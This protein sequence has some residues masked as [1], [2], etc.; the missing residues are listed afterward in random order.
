MIVKKERRVWEKK[1]ESV[2]TDSWY[3]NLAIGFESEFLFPIPITTQNGFS[4]LAQL[5]SQYFE[6][7]FSYSEEYHDYSSRKYDSHDFQTISHIEKDTS[8]KNKPLN[9]P[10]RYY[11]SMIEQ[12]TAVNLAPFELVSKV[13]FGKNVLLN[14]FDELE[15]FFCFL[16]QSKAITNESCGFH[17]TIS[18]IP[19]EQICWYR[20]HYLTGTRSILKDFN[21]DNNMYSNYALK[22]TEIN[23]EQIEILK[24]KDYRT[25]FDSHDIS[26]DKYDAIHLKEFY[27]PETDNC[28]ICI[29]FRPIGNAW[30]HLK[31]DQIR[32]TILRML[33]NLKR[34]TTTIDK[35]DIRREMRKT[36]F[37]RN[38]V[39][40][41]KE[42]GVLF[43]E[44]S[45]VSMKTKE[46][47]MRNYLTD[48]RSYES[49]NAKFFYDRE[50]TKHFYITL[51][52]LQIK[53]ESLTLR[54][55][56]IP[57]LLQDLKTLINDKSWTENNLYQRC[58]SVSFDQL[59][60]LQIFNIRSCSL[61]PWVSSTHNNF[62]FLKNKKRSKYYAYYDTA[63]KVIKNI[64]ALRQRYYKTSEFW[65]AQEDI[66][67]DFIIIPLMVSLKNKYGARTRPDNYLEA[68]R[69]FLVNVL[70][71]GEF[72]NYFEPQKTRSFYNFR[73]LFN[74]SAFGLT[75]DKEIDAIIKKIKTTYLKT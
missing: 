41:L 60:A 58:W 46:T 31:F 17:F 9:F 70:E 69:Y 75:Y 15:S 55:P 42:K 2:F 48:L 65:D 7:E 13:F 66:V 45:A 10:Y 73:A 33:W 22:I 36:F 35:K 56:E 72:L 28:T 53:N 68:L 18:G 52:K 11:S 21:R 43:H 25:F 20:Y 34:A 59:T 4:Y 19:R 23:K 24:D 30:Y 5:M 62:L 37:R 44:N 12:N 74:Y 54:F 50:S 63:K 29:E 16:A 14:F 6:T 40:L 26:M 39:D 49:K 47:L 64:T 57:F 71:G 38:E 32:G 1:Y 27:S 8:I 67:F 3:S 51:K 61:G